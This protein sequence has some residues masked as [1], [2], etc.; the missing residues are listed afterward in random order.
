MARA[1]FLFGLGE[2]ES[3]CYSLASMGLTW[4]EEGM[5]EGLDVTFAGRSVNLLGWAIC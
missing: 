5:R 2:V 1:S 3:D 4:W